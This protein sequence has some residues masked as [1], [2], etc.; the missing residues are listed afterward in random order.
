MSIQSCPSRINSLS[1]LATH[2]LV[3]GPWIGYRQT[4]GREAD[5]PA[6]C[7]TLRSSVCADVVARWAKQLRVVHR[8]HYRKTARQPGQSE[9]VSDVVVE[10]NDVG[11]E[12]PCDFPEFSDSFE[13]VAVGVES[14][15]PERDP[16]VL[17]PT[18]LR[19]L[20]MNESCYVTAFT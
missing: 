2:H 10:V 11:L 20:G 5:R 3:T 13:S 16:V 8:S 6:A 12:Q 19:R 7:V 14:G 15:N 18:L 9:E 17:A 4:M 1:N